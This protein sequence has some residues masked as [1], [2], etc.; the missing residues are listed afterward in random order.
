VTPSE[1][2]QLNENGDTAAIPA[3]VRDRIAAVEGVETVE[4]QIFD[5]GRDLP[6]KDG[7]AVLA[8]GPEVHLL[9]VRGRPLRR[10]GVRPGAGARSRRGGGARQGQRRTARASR[11]ATSSASRRVRGRRP[12]PSSG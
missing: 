8:A 11:S 7:R 3:E 4:G 5:G 6:G 12:T 2:A 10:R 9:A 1:A